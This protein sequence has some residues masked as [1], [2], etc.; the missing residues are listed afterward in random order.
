MNLKTHL[1]MYTVVVYSFKYLF[2]LLWVLVEMCVFYCI[3]SAV[4]YH[5]FAPEQ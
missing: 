4:G 3:H 2:S 1:C 5:I